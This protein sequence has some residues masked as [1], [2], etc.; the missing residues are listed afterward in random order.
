MVYY[1]NL[2][3]S[4]FWAICS[5]LLCAPAAPQPSTSGKATAT[6]D[7]IWL[8]ETL[9][10]NHAG[11]QRQDC[12]NFFSFFLGQKIKRM[13]IY[14]YNSIGVQS[15]TFV[16][17]WY[18]NT[19]RSFCGNPEA[20]IQYSSLPGVPLAEIHHFFPLLFP[21]CSAAGLRVRTANLSR[22]PKKKINKI[23]GVEHW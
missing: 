14:R 16:S 23:R 2:V 22:W 18:A 12:H 7:E 9:A 10:M 4:L 11:W 1:A 20:A 15:D 19:P 5:N 6:F 8:A 17:R 21:K 3:D 13:R